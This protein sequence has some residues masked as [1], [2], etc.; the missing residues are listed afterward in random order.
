[1]LMHYL[2]TVRV[3]L[4]GIVHIRT[5]IEV[6]VN[7]VP[8]H[9]LVTGIACCAM[10]PL[11]NV[12]LTG[13]GKLRAVIFHI[14]HSIAIPE[15]SQNLANFTHLRNTSTHAMFTYNGSMEISLMA[16]PLSCTP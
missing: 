10:Q 1:M 11:V 5:V 16:S 6:V 7:A 4:A 2:L 8:V 9:I 13:I 3:L 15:T 12:R 14:S